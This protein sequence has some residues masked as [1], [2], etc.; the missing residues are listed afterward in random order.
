VIR[1]LLKHL[2]TLLLLCLLGGGAPARAQGHE[3]L[4]LQGSKACPA[5]FPAVAAQ[6]SV[7]RGQELERL[8]PLSASCLQR[9]D[10]FAY[11]G[12]L[13][14]LQGRFVDALAALERSLLL[15]SAQL[16]V[17]LDYVLALAKT[18]DVESARALAQQ[19]LARNDAPPAMRQALESLL[20]DEQRAVDVLAR[21]QWRGSVQSL[22]GRDS[23]LNSATSADAVNLT[24][25]NG[26]VSLLLDASSKPRSGLA[27]I[28]TGH[29][30]GQT[31]L[32]GGLLV[33]Q[34]DWR[35]R[36]A[37]GNSEFG[38]R[39]QDASLLFRP[40]EAQAWAGRVAASSFAMGGTA[41]FEGLSASTWREFPGRGLSESI[42]GCNVR[43]GLEA[44]RRSYAQDRTQDGVYGSLAGL[45]LCAQG[46]NNYQLG[47]QGGRDWASVAS[48]AGGDQ[49]RLDIK[50][51]WERQW[52]WARTSAEWITSRL[53]DSRSYSDL[54]GGVTRT[55]L[56]QNLRVSV[57]K[58]LNS[59]EKLNAW[60]GLYSVT[61][62]EVLRHR[63]NIELFDVRSES[64][65]TGLRYE[66]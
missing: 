7:L 52:H 6:D 5:A 9:A 24:L 41:L 48:R 21:W 65:Y 17:Q 31:G 44:E 8:V 29:V 49:T 54:L 12:Q 56:R 15:D 25:P 45:L 36:L 59:Q 66:F 16:G 10:F 60:G 55:T 37:P 11:E 22:L 40:Y 4:Q 43:T 26:N 35:E 50:A 32:G 61:V 47:L 64:L 38:Y 19:V 13:F 57:I 33:V 53:N 58:R 1:Q 34:G 30:T 62:L 46:E 3:Q 51:A 42:S 14:L 28:T 63:S 39:Q 23:N 2:P 20:R 18:G 27:G